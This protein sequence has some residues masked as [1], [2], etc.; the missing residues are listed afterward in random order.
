M[1]RV[2]VVTGLLIVLAAAGCG[3]GSVEHEYIKSPQ[4]S[5]QRTRIHVQSHDELS[6]YRVVKGQPVNL[7]I[8]TTSGQSICIEITT[9]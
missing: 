1:N 6:G 9:D 7:H 8:H 3:G 4:Y 2:I 5:G